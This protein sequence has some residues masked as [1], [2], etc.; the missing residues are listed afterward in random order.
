MSNQ[1]ILPPENNAVVAQSVEQLPC[2]QQVESSNPSDSTSLVTIE[3]PQQQLE[4]YRNKIEIY[5]GV[6]GAIVRIKKVETPMDRSAEAFF[7]VASQM[8]KLA[9]AALQKTGAM[10]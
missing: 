6:L 4:D 3:T 1:E 2:K 8:R 5:E 9:L 10:L 7:M